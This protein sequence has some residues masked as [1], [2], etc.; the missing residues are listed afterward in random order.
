LL[1]KLK[2]TTV[3]WSAHLKSYLKTTEMK[4]LFVFFVSCAFLASSCRFMEGK[5]VRGNGELTTDQRAVG[6]FDQV[7]SFG[8]FDVEV[9][10][11]DQNM[12][13]VEADENLLRYI[14]TYIDGNTLK[15]K[16]KN[17]YSL[18]PRVRIKVMVYGPQF[19]S[20]VSNGSGNVNGQNRI[21]SPDEL[22]LEVNGSGNIRM[23]VEARSI[24]A[25]IAG[26]GNISLEGTAKKG[27]NS[28]H[29]SGNIMAGNLQTEESEVEIAGS[30][31]AEVYAT[32]SLD[33]NIM[34]SGGVHYKGAASVNSHIAGSGSVKKID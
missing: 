5:R 17:G 1:K 14:E 16:T 24:D 27:E 13:K 30:G 33:V 20:I 6:S 22:N 9:S 15:I 21:I 4:Y 25:K 34:G 28:I 29:G 8:S 2:N 3:T 26:S 12:V 18:R 19:S 32:S 23:Q 7:E 11:A 31:S 10:T